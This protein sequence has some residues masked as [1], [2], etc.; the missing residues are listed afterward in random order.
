MPK[1]T[2]IDFV[3]IVP[4]EYHRARKEYSGHPNYCGRPARYPSM[5]V[6]S[7]RIIRYRDISF[8]PNLTRKDLEK[9]VSETNMQE[10]A[11]VDNNPDRYLFYRY[12]NRPLV[13]FDRLEKKI[14]TTAGELK[15]FG[16]R[17]CQQQGSI[18]LRL[19][20]EHG[21]A[22]FKRVTITA[23]PWRIG[24]TKEDREI[25]FRALHY[26]FGDNTKKK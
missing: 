8:N 13:I 9:V 17:A 20:K 2:T 6:H 12:G 10:K 24:Y 11:Y 21:H 15:K 22:N 14:C 4:I 1:K 26:L 7:P 16:E 23:N 18:L 5:R 3:E 25:T 19:L